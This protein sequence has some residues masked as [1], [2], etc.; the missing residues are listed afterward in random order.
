MLDSVSSV[1]R[2]ALKSFMEDSEDKGEF[3]DFISCF[4]SVASQQS[5]TDCLGSYEINFKF[6][7]TS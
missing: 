1:S 4:F 6:F 2:R 5:I 3:L 7:T